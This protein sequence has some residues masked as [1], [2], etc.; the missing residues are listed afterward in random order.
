MTSHSNVQR[1]ASY[2]Y[3]PQSHTSAN[4]V[5]EHSSSTPVAQSHTASLGSS[6]TVYRGSECDSSGAN[7]RI[8]LNTDSHDRV[9][10]DVPCTSAVF[11]LFKYTG[12][13]TNCYGSKS[14]PASWILLSTCA[15]A[16][17]KSIAD[18]PTA[19]FELWTTN[20]HSSWTWTSFSFSFSSA[21]TS[22]SHSSGFSYIQSS[23]DFPFP[24]SFS[25]SI[26]TTLFNIFHSS[27]WTSTS[28]HYPCTSAC[29]CAITWICKYSC[30]PSPWSQSGHYEPSSDRIQLAPIRRTSGTRQEQ[31]RWTPRK[32][33]IVRHPLMR[34]DLRPQMVSLKW[35]E[36]R[37]F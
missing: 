22:G 29:T 21:R 25:S 20:L 18:Y 26:C 28:A 13:I 9:W 5:S 3:H 15:T 14:Y 10:Y 16:A 35:M 6:D 36:R 32:F 8:C 19:N 33:I 4:V 24:L 1:Q 17:V 31:E 2:P 30:T 23:V 7:T 11:L 34:L 37:V 12:S 27:S